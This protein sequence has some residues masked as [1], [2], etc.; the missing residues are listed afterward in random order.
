MA[1]ETDTRAFFDEFYPRIYRFVRMETGESHADVEEIAQD[2]LFH[3]WRDRAAF[4]SQA[5]PFAWMKAIA[6]HRIYERRRKE[7]R[8][9]KADAVLHA[10]A[11]FD[12]EL[13]PEEILG[14]GELRARVWAALER[15]GKDYAEILILRYVED[16]SVR[17]IAEER[18]E[19]EKAVESRLHRAREAFR[20]AIKSGE[21][22]EP[23]D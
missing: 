11:R 2:V 15:I 22:H 5:E 3:A 6:R 20:Q 9:E 8:K 7:G 1:A 18:G 14:A 21:P 10:L 17:A 16:R 13:L 23:R 4:R 12:T 19:S